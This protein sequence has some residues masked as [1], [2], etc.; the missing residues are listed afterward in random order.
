MDPT[1]IKSQAMYDARGVHRDQAFNALE[2]L[3]GELAVA[4]ARINALEAEI[5]DLKTQGEVGDAS[6]PAD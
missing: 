6:S 1:A 2:A 5:A 4:Q 3:Y